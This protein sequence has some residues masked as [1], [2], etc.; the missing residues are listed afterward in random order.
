MWS[1]QKASMRVLYGWIN[2]LEYSIPKLYF[3]QP[4]KYH[5]EWENPQEKLNLSL[6]DIYTWKEK[7]LDIVQL[8]QNMNLWLRIMC[9]WNAWDL[10][11]C[12]Y[13]R[14]ILPPYITKILLKFVRTHSVK[15]SHKRH[16]RNMS[17]QS[18]GCFVDVYK[19]RIKKLKSFKCCNF[20]C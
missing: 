2:V 5:N 10:I 11:A 20:C 4:I 1:W 9:F 7:W 12:I 15:Q 13:E 3:A 6:L 8:Y 19:F 18:N 14:N 17:G 16:W